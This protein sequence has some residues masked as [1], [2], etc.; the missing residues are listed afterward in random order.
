MKRTLKN[1]NGEETQSSCLITYV[2]FKITSS[3]SF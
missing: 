2:I 3:G 1:G